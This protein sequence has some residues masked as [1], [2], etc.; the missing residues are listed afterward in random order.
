MVTSLPSDPNAVPI[1]PPI[2]PAPRIACFIASQPK[3]FKIQSPRCYNQLKATAPSSASA[4]S[5][6]IPFASKSRKQSSLSDW[7]ADLHA[8]YGVHRILERLRAHK[9]EE[10]F[11]A[12]VAR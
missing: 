11:S 12:T 6:R 4:P 5:N 3:S 9:P 1:R 8:D 2:A 10:R 7:D